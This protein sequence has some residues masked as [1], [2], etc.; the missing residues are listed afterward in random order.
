MVLAMGFSA[1]AAQVI[2]LRRFIIVFGG[3]ELVSSAVLAGWLLWSGIGNAI[4]GRFADRIRDVRQALALALFAMALA[5]PLTIIAAGL[6]KAALGLPPPVLVGLPTMMASALL[7]MAPHGLLIGASFTLACK[8]PGMES[9]HD[10]GHVYALDTIGSAVG[11]IAFS[12]VAIRYCTPLQSALIIAGALVLAVGI[13]ATR[14]HIKLE[15]L[16]L[17]FLLSSALVL[18]PRIEDRITA[19]QW[20]G[21]RPVVQRESRFAGL[22]VTD[23]RGERTLFIDGRPSFSLPLL[24][25]YETAANFPLSQCAD[26]RDVLVIGGGISGMVV[27]L[28]PWDLA[29]AHFVR[30][31][32]EVT[33]LEWT[34]MP[35]TMGKHPLWATLHHTDGRKFIRE[36]LD[37]ACEEACLDAII[38][39]VGDPDTAAADRYFTVEFFAEARRLLRPEGVLALALLEPANALGEEQAKV[40][41]SVRAS[42]GRVFPKIVILPFERFWFVASGPL[43]PLT[44]DPE[45]IDRRLGEREISAEHFR[46]RML[47]GLFPERIAQMKLAVERAAEGS[48]V[49]RD[50]K[51]G[52]YYA[53]LLLWEARTGEAGRGTLGALA[54]VKMWMAAATIALL[55][56]ATAFAQRKKSNARISA[57]WTMA[58]IGFGTMAYEVALIVHYQMTMGLLVWRIGIIITA[59][60]IGAGAGAFAG[61]R[62]C[63]RHEPSQRLVALAL[64]VAALF[65]LLEPIVT[66]ASFFLANALLGLM[67]GFIYQLAAAKLVE[68]GLGVG[69]AAGIIESSDHW[70]AAFGALVAGIVAIPLWGIIPTLALGATTLGAAAAV[71][72]CSADSSPISQIPA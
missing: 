43:A 16:A 61:I 7:L 69:R 70:G 9:P 37:G 31:D 5:T 65:L 28:T 34:A 36:G 64:L 33:Y 1:M 20:R 12:L 4:A 24:E 41:G 6:V 62:W 14:R 68:E 11:G 10:I 66:V 32:P 54:H 26:P 59:F 13:S 52:A 19:V 47:A 8:S 40:L 63:E 55:A 21:F 46:T 35:S 3:N 53:G 42:L 67:S 25:T 44:D 49:N 71:C 15:A 30:L 18:S 60:M 27:E 45:E 56:A 39:D 72:A 38:I 50:T 23:N 22:M 48:P 51:P 29:N 57:V 58:A 17:M 2:L